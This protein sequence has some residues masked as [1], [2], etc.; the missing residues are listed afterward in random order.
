VPP[1]NAGRPAGERAGAAG[2][3]AGFD[4]LP[5]I[6]LRAGRVVDLYQG[7]YAQ[8]TVYETTPEAV[9]ADFVRDGGRC[10]HI[11]D[12]DGARSGSPANRDAVRRIAATATAAG[13]RLELGGGMRS[14]E[15]ARAALDLGVT[16]VIFGTAAVERPQLVAEA[17]RALG[18]QAV[19][20]GMDARQGMVATRGW[21][22]ASSVSA[23]T[24]AQ[25]LSRLG[26]ERFIYTD[27]ARDS[28]LTE[29][30]FAE[31]EAMQQAVPAR[32]IASGG[33]T[34]AEQV[35]RLVGLGLEGA[36]IGSALYAGKIT[37]AQ[38]LAAARGAGGGEAC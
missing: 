2:G 6:D 4:V 16:R 1:A 17:V 23:I 8:E 38:A 22:E 30:N 3:G 7:D 26:V 13:V 29:P 24:L 15:A 9:A 33:V 10:I 20:V 36:I 11:V 34:S 18:P 31:L 12:L 28:T 27:I 37:L 5:S 21:T 35:T 14:L 32:I 19:V 25:Q